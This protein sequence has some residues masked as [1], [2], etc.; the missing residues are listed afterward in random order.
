[1]KYFYRIFCLLFILSCCKFLQAHQDSLNNH[2]TVGYTLRTH[3]GGIYK[4][5]PAYAKIGSINNTFATEL[6]IILPKCGTH[7]WHH[8]F[9]FPEVMFTFMYADFG[10]I[11]LGK[12]FSALANI[13]MDA[14]KTEAFSIYLRL[15]AGAA[16][17]TERFDSVLN[18]QNEI[19]GSHINDVNKLGIGANINFLQN[20]R[21]GG[22][23]SLTHFSNGSV[24]KPNRGINLRS[25]ELAL[26]YIPT[27][28]KYIS[29][30]YTC[31]KKRKVGIL[32]KAG[33]GLTNQYEYPNKIFEVWNAALVSNF[34]IGK[35]NAIQLGIGA[36]YNWYFHQL[37][38][39]VQTN[40]SSKNKEQISMIIGDELLFGKTG[41]SYQ[42]HRVINNAMQN[43]FWRTRLG[44]NYYF[45]DIDLK[46]CGRSFLGVGLISHKFTALY[47]EVCAGFVF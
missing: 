40:I 43:E 37:L 45:T 33:W 31:N 27:F 3:I 18:P 30:L 25:I 21:I 5:S 13:K 35:Y 7:N 11:Y 1:M 12:S 22:G 6:G 28:E 44:L 41:I 36:E 39:D 8:A 38:N 17:I 19:I 2:N 16:F 42:M 29:P 26:S 23:I 47:A 32:L 24:K 46:R 14:I 10:N 20:W 4:H 34:F 9:N 15:G